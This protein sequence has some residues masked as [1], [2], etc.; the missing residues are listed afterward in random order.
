METPVS[1]HTLDSPVLKELNSQ[2][3]KYKLETMS[4]KCR[5]AEFL[6]CLAFI[7]VGAIEKFVENDLKAEERK[8]YDQRNNVAVILG[9]LFSRPLFNYVKHEINKDLCDPIA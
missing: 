3:S 1:T 5:E 2:H 8:P 7:A 6:D 9:E 4:E